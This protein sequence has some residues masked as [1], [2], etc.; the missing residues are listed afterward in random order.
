MLKCRHIF[1]LFTAIALW[2]VAGK[3]VCMAQDTLQYNIFFRQGEASLDFTFRANRDALE[4]L[5]RCVRQ[6][7]VLQ[8]T[9]CAGSSVEGGLSRNLQLAEDRAVL[10]RGW[11]LRSCKMADNKIQVRS[12]G[13]DW[14]GLRTYAGQ[15]GAPWGREVLDILEHTPEELW[16]ERLLSIRKGQLWQELMDTAFP[17]LRKVVVTVVTLP[18]EERAVPDSAPAAEASPTGIPVPPSETYAAAVPVRPRQTIL[19][20]RTNALAVP[21]LNVGVE[22]PLGNRW[23]VGADWYYPWLWRSSHATGVDHTGK[24]MEALALNLE[25]R[26]WPGNRKARLLG[27]SAGVF[28]MAGYYDLERNFHGFQGEFAT[29]GLDYLYACPLFKGN[30]HL[31]LSL[32]LGYFYSQ[33]REYWVY[34]EGGKGYREKDMAKTIRY[35]GP[36]KATVSLVVPI[37]GGKRR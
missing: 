21:F 1:L 24:C 15:T 20:F 36:V 14:D 12:L 26:Y 31:E 17:Q 23:S 34:H 9:I 27:H 2:T 10:V 13:I 19:A 11:L 18:G 30:M 29:G 22:V 4:E 5:R 33:A 7:P 6:R 25:V 32:G 37:K 16:K 3:T 28:A 8:V 35:W